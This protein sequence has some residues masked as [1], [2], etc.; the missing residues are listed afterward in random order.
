MQNFRILNSKET[1]EI[2]S[3]LK[4]QFDFTAKLDYAFLKNK[5]DIYLISKDLGKIDTKKFR[6]NNL[7]LY[8]G[9]VRNNSLRLSIEASQLIGSKSGKNILT[10]DNEQVLY[11]I[12]GENLPID[13]N[14]KGYVLIKH[15]EDYLGCGY[16][17]DK[18]LINYV[19]KERRLKL[20]EI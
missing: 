3:L 18:T 5:D 8:F 12:A 9:E 13:T 19:P 6:I 14:L 1:K 20:T 11:W 4:S 10:L 16:V 7:G 2:L 17:K 15:E